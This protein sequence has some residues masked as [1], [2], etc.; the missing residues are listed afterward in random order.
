MDPN[1]RIADFAEDFVGEFLHWD[2][3]FPATI[4]ALMARPGFLTKEFLV[5][6]RRSWLS[7]FRLYLTIS[8]VYFLTPPLLE[9]VFHHDERAIAKFQV[10]GD[11]SQV[12]DMKLLGDSA[13]FVNSQETQ[14]NAV[15]RILGGPAKAWQLMKNPGML[16]DIIAEA[17]PKAMFI[18]MP[19]FALLTWLAWRST[20]LNYPAH[21]VFSFHVHSAFFAALWAMKIMEPIGSIP[22][23]IAAQLV[24]L[25][26]STWYVVR[27][28]RAALGGTTRQVVA[29]S[30]AV[31]LVYM[32]AALAIVLGSIV[33]ALSAA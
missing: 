20:G 4:R 22:L 15:I 7:P 27:A 17:I 18:L 33:I 29:R 21:L 24:F 12:E 9:R 19:F 23:D 31:G 32:P 2:G 6:K 30:S 10:T 13:A 5:G 3:K 11:S 16:K 8:I 25:I 14:G 1:P 28:S 26:Y